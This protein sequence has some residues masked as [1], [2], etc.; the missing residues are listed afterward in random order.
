MYLSSKTWTCVCRLRLAS[1][2]V[3]SI[4][5]QRPAPGVRGQAW[6]SVSLPDILLLVEVKYDVVTQLLYKEML[7]EHYSK[8]REA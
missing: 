2:G 7:Q 1:E 4:L 8:R 6:G 5:C 3:Y